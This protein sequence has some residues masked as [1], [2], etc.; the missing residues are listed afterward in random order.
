MKSRMIDGGF[1]MNDISIVE[2][3]AEHIGP[4]YI[5][6]ARAERQGATHIAIE[7]VHLGTLTG[8]ATATAI[9]EASEKAKARAVKALQADGS[10]EES[11]PP[12]ISGMSQAACRCHC[13]KPDRTLNVWDRGLSL[14]LTEDD[15]KA[16]VKALTGL[17]A[18][19]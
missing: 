3:T 2:L 11:G 16:V 12:M 13:D 4:L 1:A 9:R 8:E 5:I 10:A 17:P 6:K 19:R 7:A 15:L 18:S 14:N